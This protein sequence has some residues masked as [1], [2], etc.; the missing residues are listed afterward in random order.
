MNGKKSNEDQKRYKFGIR[1]KTI[2]SIVV[3]GSITV[4]SSLGIIYHQGTSEV[5]KVI[6]NDFE[7]L[8]KETA[9]KVDLI[10]S[11]ESEFIRQ[12][13]RSPHVKEML[14][15]ANKVYEGLSAADVE[16]QVMRAER[17]WA[18][19][20]TA[21]AGQAIFLDPQ[22]VSTLEHFTKPVL[23]NPAYFAFY[24]VDRQGALIASTRQFPDYQNA[25]KH[26]RQQAIRLGGEQIYVSDLYFHEKVNN[27]AVDMAVAI[28]EE[29]FKDPIGVLKIEYNI[30]EFL[31][32][33]IYPIRFGK[34]GHAMLIDAAGD[35][36]ICPL[37]PTGIHVPDKNLITAVTS[38]K[39]GWVI[40]E[41]DGHG[42]N[43]SLV[44]FSPLE[45]YNELVS[46]AGSK[47][48]YSFIRQDPKEGNA[49][50]RN[51]L[52]WIAFSGLFGMTILGVLGYYAA[53]QLTHAFDAMNHKLREAYWELEAKVE[54]RT[55]QLREAQ[56]KLVQSERLASM[57]QVS[58]SIGHELRNPLSVIKNA[59]FYLKMKIKEE[60]KLVKH[61]DLIDKEVVGSERIIDDLLSFTRSK[62]VVKKL[63]DI[64]L[65][66]DEAL[67][68]LEIPVGVEVV[69]DFDRQLP[70]VNIDAEQMQRVFINLAQ[71]AIQAMEGG[72]S[73]TIR[74]KKRAEWIDIQIA[75]TGKGMTP[76]NREKIF[77]PFFT[78][79][80]KG[81]GLGLAISKK[82]LDQ[83][84]ATISVQS[85][86]GKGASFTVSLP[87]LSR[88]E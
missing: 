68:V 41:N 11:N 77:E 23:D 18:S 40:A 54:E 8:A 74:T 43:N 60:P 29:R 72:G 19:A 78:T 52:G 36:I 33:A 49:P 37:L 61:L 81:I 38:P 3:V 31:K 73:F 30:Q 14:T 67:S 7:G 83:H 48:W 76:E 24:I 34:T 80:A 44:G 27:Y 51:L 22:A 26:W 56:A 63:T 84:H 82:I 62:D 5:R 9:R 21:L 64:H 58:A 88:E 4:L 75:D 16:A 15:K 39:S 10:M 28:A 66:I 47:K 42:G 35:V 6:G 71:N 45:M 13:A 70:P 1:G 32:P 79:K 65:L 20:K 87:L 50:I 12:A 25:E 53:N 69:R 57:G 85:E 46:R 86:I 55:K 2:T 59:V 17:K